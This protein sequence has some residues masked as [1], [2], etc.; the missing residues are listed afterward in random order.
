VDDLVQSIEDVLTGGGG[1]DADAG[2]SPT[3]II[4]DAGPSPTEII[5]DDAAIFIPNDRQDLE[6]GGNND[7]TQ[8]EIWAALERGDFGAE[9]SQPGDE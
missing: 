7:E 1:T 9:A 8:K 4:R 3:G 5:P 6:I 2:L